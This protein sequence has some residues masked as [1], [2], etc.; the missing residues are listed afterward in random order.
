MMHHSARHPISMLLY[1]VLL[2]WVQ[3]YCIQHLFSEMLSFEDPSFCRIP[4]L[5]LGSSLRNAVCC[6]HTEGVA[7][8]STECCCCPGCCAAHF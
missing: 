2:L 1:F 6:T 8:Q 7:K 4:F 3:Q 5:S